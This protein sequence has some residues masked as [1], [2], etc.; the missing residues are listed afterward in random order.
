MRTFGKGK[1]KRRNQFFLFG[2]HRKGDEKSKIRITFNPMH[3][4][5]S[6]SAFQ[7]MNEVEERGERMFSELKPC[8][9]LP[10]S[11]F[12]ILHILSLSLTVSQMNW[13]PSTTLI[14]N[15]DLLEHLVGMF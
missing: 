11:F 6:Y 3:F 8:S 5:H 10:F 9:L 1:K 14:C 15:W 2:L 13:R 7:R 12:Y 4:Q